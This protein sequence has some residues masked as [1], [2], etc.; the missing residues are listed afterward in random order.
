MQQAMFHGRPKNVE[1]D[2]LQP[3]AI[4]LDVHWMSGA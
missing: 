1:A 3:D 4:T 2:S